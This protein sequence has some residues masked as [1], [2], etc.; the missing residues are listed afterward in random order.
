MC[1]QTIICDKTIG[2]YGFFAY[3]SRGNRSVVKLKQKSTVWI[4][5]QNLNF[6]QCI[7]QCIYTT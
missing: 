6:Y 5:S 1:E 4:Y 3:L 2:R 7:V